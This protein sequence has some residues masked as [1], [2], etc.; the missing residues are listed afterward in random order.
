M[1]A[2]RGNNTYRKSFRGGRGRG[3]HTGDSGRGGYRGKTKTVASGSL[4]PTDGTSNAEKFESARISNQ[5]DE[6]MGFPRY[7][8]GPKKVGWLV[9]MHTVCNPST[10]PEAVG[11]T[12]NAYLDPINRRY[13]RMIHTPVGKQLWIFTFWMILGD[14]LR[15]H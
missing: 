2:G 5:I 12:D 9:N 10:L 14:L 8:S 13:W 4:L 1:S 15:L 6:A 7:E 11:P 3:G